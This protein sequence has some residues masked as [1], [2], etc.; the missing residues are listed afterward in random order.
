M[1]VRE[2]YEV[3]E[4]VCLSTLKALNLKTKAMNLIAGIDINAT[5]NAGTFN[6]AKFP[7]TMVYAICEAIRENEVWYSLECRQNAA[8]D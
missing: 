2:Y 8:K 1:M 4:N 7:E 3:M 6:E 5:I